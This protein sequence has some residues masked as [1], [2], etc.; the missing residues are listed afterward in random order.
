MKF[1]ALREFADGERR[2]PLSPDSIPRLTALG[3]QVVV[4]A[5]AGEAAGFT[6]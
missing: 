6:D 4:E 3:L 1:S 5:G 2:I